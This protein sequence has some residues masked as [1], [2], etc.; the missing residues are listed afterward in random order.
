MD[1]NPIRLYT[2][3]A[4]RSEGNLGGWG[5]WSEDVGQRRWTALGKWADNEWEGVRE[6]S[7]LAE[8]RAVRLAM[9]SLGR[10]HR[11][12]ERT[13]I[14]CTDNQGTFFNIEKAGSSAPGIHQECRRLFWYC[15]QKGIQLKA[16]WIPRVQ[17]QLA[18]LLLENSRSHR[19]AVIATR[20]RGCP[21]PAGAA[22]YS[23][24]VCI[25]EHQPPSK[26]L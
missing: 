6:S 25:V 13:V 19:L 20:V 11:L 16:R 12:G 2:D 22:I 23:R 26:I 21:T 5:A 9:E 17:N 24:H 3:A 18:E 7:T 1:F 14:V 4:G 15:I 10:A 8:M